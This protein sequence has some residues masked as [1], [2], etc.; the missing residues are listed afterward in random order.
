MKDATTNLSSRGK[1]LQRR[2]PI[3]DAFKRKAEQI[4]RFVLQRKGDEHDVECIDEKARKQ[5]SSS[6]PCQT[7][8]KFPST[9]RCSSRVPTI[10]EKKIDESSAP[11]FFTH[12]K[13]GIWRSLLIRQFE[14]SKYRIRC[15]SPFESKAMVENNS[16]HFSIP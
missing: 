2:G 6:R 15:E 4:E 13:D 1:R 3:A 7:A 16:P 5:G 11:H 14:P 8:Q 9:M 12:Q 10:K